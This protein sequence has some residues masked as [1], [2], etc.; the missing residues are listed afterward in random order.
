MPAFQA[1]LA[2]HPPSGPFCIAAPKE[3][4]VVDE[5]FFPVSRAFCSPGTIVLQIVVQNVVQ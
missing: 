2:M 1:A 4:T 5:Y 3:D